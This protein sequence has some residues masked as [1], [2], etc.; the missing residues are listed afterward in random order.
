MKG[1]DQMKSSHS[2]IPS[3]SSQILQ[4]C[5]IRGNQKGKHD[6][7]L[8]CSFSSES[9]VLSTVNIFEMAQAQLLH[10]TSKK[11]DDP[12][13]ASQPLNSHSDLSLEVLDD[14]QLALLLQASAEMF[15]KRHYERATE[16]LSLC[17]LSASLTGTPVQRVVYYYSEALR[18]KID[19]ETKS[20]TGLQLDRLVDFEVKPTGVEELFLCSKPHSEK[21]LHLIDFGIRSGSHSTILM[22]ALANR[23][24][25]PLELL[26]ITA[27]GTSKQVVDETGKRLSSFAAEN[28]KFPFFFKA[29]VSEMK[30]LSKD[31]FELDTNEVVVVYSEYILGGMLAWPNHL[32][33]VLRFIKNLNP[34]VIV[35]I[36][37][38][39]NTNEPIFMDLFNGSVFLYA[40][41]FDCLEA[42]MERDNQH[43]M[44]FERLVLREVIHNV[45]TCEGEGRIF[46]NVRLEVWRALFEKFGIKETELSE[47]SLYQA[48]LMADRSAH[49]FCTLDMDGNCLT[50]KWKGT[51]IVF[52]SAWK[53]VHD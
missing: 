11:E 38:E 34:C 4:K 6:C 39:A 50:I 42:F 10:H 3:A 36:E 28:M 2:C 24:D 16:L 48:N 15:S 52:A 21:R 49:G 33:V 18:E 19:K 22:Q 35:V 32:E 1:K 27:I 20:I 8:P 29:V 31:L 45:I 14:F 51:P 9:H 5:C 41:L 46:R 53:F 12:S 17:N 43:R 23:G 26:K 47:S 13:I 30:D 37:T 7:D 25:Y 44:E 40:A